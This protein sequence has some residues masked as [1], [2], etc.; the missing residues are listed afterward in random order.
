MTKRKIICCCC[1]NDDNDDGIDALFPSVIPL[2]SRMGL[3]VLSPNGIEPEFIQIIDPESYYSN[4]D[5][6]ESRDLGGG[7]KCP[8]YDY[9]IYAQAD[10]TAFTP[11]F[12]NRQQK[13]ID[14]FNTHSNHGLSGS[15][16]YTDGTWYDWDG[17]TRKTPF[18][19]I[20]ATVAESDA[21]FREWY[22]FMFP[23]YADNFVIRGLKQLYE[24]VQPF[25]DESKPTV[26]EFELWS[27]RVLNHV[28]DLLGLP[29]AYMSQEW[30]IR[31]AW[32]DERK[33]SPL[34]DNGELANGSAYGPC[35]NPYS[36]N[37]HCGETFVPPEY[38]DQRPYWNDYLSNTCVE[39]PYLSVNTSHS[40]A[41]GVWWNGTAMTWMSRNM[42]SW[43]SS[44]PT[45]HGGPFLGRTVYGFSRYGST[46]G[47]VR[48]KWT[49]SSISPPP[50][51]KWAV[52]A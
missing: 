38:D 17:V 22:D 19:P 48:F 30:M 7:K 41:V 1:Q 24:T 31:C 52:A 25:A 5:Y 34:W 36:S 14:L 2:V 27:E 9:E 13:L 16:P 26:R 37:I 28:R 35:F 8:S 12:N 4:N 47:N 11:V 29:F 43:L 18:V 10:L 46:G 39:H 45:G 21:V 23:N 50:G 40:G 6:L 42:R 3:G 51:Y 20:S 44:G 49:G 33:T 32:S 15:L